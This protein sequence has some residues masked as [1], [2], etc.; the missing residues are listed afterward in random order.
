AEA[1]PGMHRVMM[2]LREGDGGPPPGPWARAAAGV[3]RPGAGVAESCDWLPHVYEE[4]QCPA[5]PCYAGRLYPERTEAVI[6]QRRARDREALQEVLACIARDVDTGGRRPDE[7]GGAAPARFSVT[8]AEDLER[9]EGFRFELLVEGKPVAPLEDVRRTLDSIAQDF[10]HIPSEYLVP[11]GHGRYGPGTAGPS[12]ERPGRDLED[13]GHRY[14]EWDHARRRYRKDW[15]LLYEKDVHPQWDDFVERTRRKYRG[16]LKE[17]SRTFEALRGEDRKLKRQPYGDDI[18]LDAVIESY[19]DRRLGREE[20]QRQFQKRRRV[21]RDV[22][23]MFLVD[24][25]GS[26]KG[27][28]ND[29]ERE[30]LV[31]LCESLETLGDR[32]AIYGFSGYSHR[33]CEVFRVKRMEEEYT[34]EVRARISGIW[35]QD[36]T[37][38]GAAIRHTAGLLDAVEART[39]LLVTISDGRPDDQDGYRGPYGV[40]DTRQALLE[41]KHRG[42]HPYCV[43]IDLEAHEYLPRM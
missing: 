30:A 17:L 34:E 3:E 31:L 9:P 26:T 35:P 6:A 15:C 25:S 41:A 38:M 4:S 12:G 8:R 10:G 1:L 39:R 2:G 24:M 23:V 14:D 21:E 40:E 42:I 18:D 43:T 7:D 22:A 32:Y 13:K 36:Y 28:I 19:V 20:A 11:A 29:A 16:L 27:W 37:R 33:R 5:L